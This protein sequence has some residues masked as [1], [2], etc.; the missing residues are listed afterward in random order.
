VLSLPHRLRVLCA[1]DADACALVWRV[2]VRTVSGTS[3][4]VRAVPSAPVLPPVH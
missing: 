4:H 1:Y 3:A 2:L